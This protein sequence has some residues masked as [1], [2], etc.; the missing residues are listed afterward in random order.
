MEERDKVCEWF[1]LVN[2]VPV[3]PLESDMYDFNETLRS[4]SSSM[5][6]TCAQP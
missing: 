6:K 5:Y 1:F 4:S 3:D 2:I